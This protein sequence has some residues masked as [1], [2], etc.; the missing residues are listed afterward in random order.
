MG[1]KSSRDFHGFEIPSS[2]RLHYGLLDFEV[3][4]LTRPLIQRL[5]QFNSLGKPSHCEAPYLKG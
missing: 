5:I 4:N 2:P 1:I 3:F